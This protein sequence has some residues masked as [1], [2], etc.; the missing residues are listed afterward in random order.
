[1]ARSKALPA[2]KSQA[3]DEESLLLRSAESLGRMIGTLQ[4][5]LDDAARR[6]SISPA[7]RSRP[8][9][10]PASENGGRHAAGTPENGKTA[11]S[12][13]TSN[14]AARAKTAAKKT[15]ARTSAPTPKGRVKTAKKSVRA[16]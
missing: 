5:Q 4:R 9:S 14:G 1:M 16:R 11:S 7:K 15:T 10:H 12:R 6:L 3:R 8:K 13:S 2:R